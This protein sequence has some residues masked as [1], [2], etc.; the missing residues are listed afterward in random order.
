[1]APESDVAAAWTCPT[2]KTTVE[3]PYC[4]TCGEHPVRPRDLTL[5]GLLAQLFHA[6]SSIDGRLISSVRCLLTR[7]GALTVA[8]ANGPR[9][10]Y[11]GP[12]QLFLVANVVFVAAQSLTGMN[13]FSSP[14]DS[15]LHHQD[16]SPVAQ[17]LVAHRLEAAHSTLERYAPVFNRSV[18]LHAKSLIILMTVPFSLLLP[19]VFFAKRKSFGVHVVFAVH[20][21]A[22]LLF[23]ACVSLAMAEIDVLCGGTGLESAWVDNALSAFNLAACAVYLYLATGTVYGAKGAARVIASLGLAVAFAA[24]ALGYRFGLFLFTL[25]VT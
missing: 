21:Y 4:P 24:I 17:R 7:P 19:V 13:V 3:S 9:K 25:Y 18:A 20:V 10:L 12:F 16:W 23:L 14:L 22:F 6:T 15:H 2:C 8:Y 1:M 11:L 5:R